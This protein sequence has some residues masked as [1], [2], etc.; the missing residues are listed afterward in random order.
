MPSEEATRVSGRRFVAH[1]ADG[2][3]I[4]IVLFV[5]GIPAAIVSDTLLAIV[6]VVWLIFGQLAYYVLFERRDGRTPGKR[7]SGIKV[8]D[9][10][11]GVPTTGA[12]VKRTLPLY[13]EYFYV[14][15][16]I[17]MMSS[18]YRQRLGDRWGKTY[19]VAD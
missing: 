16:W 15:A 6:L 14:F 4:G 19:V 1:L 18:P 5:L 10:Q 11:G 17:A 2:V 9:A 12:L 8:V 13:V 3:L 7:L